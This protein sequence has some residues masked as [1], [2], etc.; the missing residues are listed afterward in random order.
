[1]LV[2]GLSL[3]LN[4]RLSLIFLSLKPKSSNSQFVN[5]TVGKFLRISLFS[6]RFLSS[7]FF[8][9]FEFSFISAR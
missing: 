2:A 9:W 7:N 1:M 6:L 3:L 8:R 4:P 5:L